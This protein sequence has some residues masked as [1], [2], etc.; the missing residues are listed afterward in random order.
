MN[1]LRQ[2]PRA[3]RDVDGTPT[4]A[5][6]G[7][8]IELQRT[9]LIARWSRRID[10]DSA[11]ANETDTRTM[12]EDGGCLL[13]Q[14]SLALQGNLVDWR[15][16]AESYTRARISRSTPPRAVLAELALL[17]ATL[18]ASANDWGVELGARAHALLDQALSAGAE[19]FAAE[20]RQEGEFRDRLIGRLSH[21]LRNPLSAIKL[22][23][24]ML[25]RDHQPPEAQ[26]RTLKR[27][28]SST[29]RMLRMIEDLQDFSRLRQGAALVLERRPADLEEIC[30]TA[31]RDLELSQAHRQVQF[32]SDGQYQGEW[33]VARLAQALDSVLVGAAELGTAS[34]LR[35]RL[36][37][38]DRALAQV[39]VENP[40]VH[41]PADQLRALFDPFNQVRRAHEGDKKT[42][43][44]G[45]GL[46][47]AEQ[48][49][50]AHGG[51][52]SA[53]SEADRGT[54]FTISLPA[55]LHKDST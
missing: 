55:T 44:L 19:V 28:A 29:N 24:S 34:A 27:I 9:A 8:L 36:L 5:D 50:R 43:G 30:R 41:V 53:L 51:T 49:V 47:I 16:A 46:F 18:L 54:T 4:P 7:E 15:Q 3:D 33:D 2:Y 6:I 14:L 17:R 31:L 25:M 10:E 37:H 11:L 12:A 42:R 48:I 52:I 22:G 45:L 13:A 38:R 26:K 35:L 40:D 23:T 1:S 39:L 32:A 20:F 21:D